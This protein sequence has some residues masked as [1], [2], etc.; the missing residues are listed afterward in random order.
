MNREYY[1]L[2]RHQYPRSR[3][4]STGLFQ[5]ILSIAQEIG[6]DNAL[7]CLEQCV[8]EKRLSWWDRNVE[9]LE[10]TGNPLRDGY[11]MFYE[12]YLGL[13]TPQD[14][15]IV[16]A[17]D[18]RLVTRWWN[19]CSTLAACQKLGLDTREICRK[20]Y[21][22]P[23]QVLLSKIDPRLRFER[24]YAALRPYTPYCEEIIRLEE[25]DGCGPVQNTDAQDE[26]D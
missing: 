25:A 3:G 16:E 10:R 12:G 5:T 4:D 14:G 19:P 24:N 11:R 21:H 1:Q 6:W 7:A 17:T 2:V 15:E 8:I 22:Q 23:V 9:T 26:T 20:V 18:R 13:S